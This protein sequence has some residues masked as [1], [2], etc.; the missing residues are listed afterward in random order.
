MIK[1]VD[2]NSEWAIEFD[3]IKLFL[4]KEI[5][6]N[7]IVHIGSTSVIGLAAKPIIDLIILTEEDGKNVVIQKLEKLGYTHIGDLGITGREAFSPN[8]LIKSTLYKHNLYCGSDK[9]FHVKNLLSLSK[10]LKVNPNYVKKYSNLKNE[11]SKLYPNDIDM[12][13][14]AK[15][16]LI[17]EM[18]KL[19]GM[20]KKDLDSIIEVNK[21]K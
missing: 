7:K 3:R 21:V 20:S 10:F 5:D 15:T 2:Y 14:E 8:E 11:N 19:S 6:L 16:D 4:E 12:Y 9:N 13:V 18:L 1:V 17:I